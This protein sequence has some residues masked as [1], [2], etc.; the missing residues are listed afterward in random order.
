MKEFIVEFVKLNLTHLVGSQKIYES[1]QYENNSIPSN[2]ITYESTLKK[3]R[4]LIWQII[5]DRKK[6]KIC[7]ITQFIIKNHIE[8]VAKEK[9]RI[10]LIFY[11]N[12]SPDE[13]GWYERQKGQ[14]SQKRYLAGIK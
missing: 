10:F 12:L 9:K 3:N 4:Q 6:K 5:H 8:R 7:L 11:K 1:N 13:T 14:E 2:K